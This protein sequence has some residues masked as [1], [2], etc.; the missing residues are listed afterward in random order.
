MK[1]T[2]PETTHIDVMR[3]QLVKLVLFFAIY[4]ISAKKVLDTSAYQLITSPKHD[5][6]QH[7]LVNFLE[8]KR[9]SRLS[10]GK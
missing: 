6:A 10:E 8:Q 5:Y 7:K 1:E 9:R 2:L 3:F 4:S